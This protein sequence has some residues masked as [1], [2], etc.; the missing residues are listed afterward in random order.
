MAHHRFVW[1]HPFMDGNGRVA[2]ILL[3]AMLRTCELNQTGVWSMSRVFAKS[4]AEYKNKLTG[5]ELGRQGDYDER[6]NLSGKKLVG[7]NTPRECLGHYSQ[8]VRVDLKPE[9]EKLFMHAT[10]EGESDRMEA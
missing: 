1:I 10:I 9:S 6:G 2:R 5:V 7:F 3:D 4:H 8:I